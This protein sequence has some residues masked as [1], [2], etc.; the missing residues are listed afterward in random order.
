LPVLDRDRPL[1]IRGDDL[2]DYIKRTRASRK[3]RTAPDEFY[4]LG[5]RKA[6]GAAGS[7]ADCT[8]RDG[9]ATLTALCEV[10][11][12]VVYKPA[13]EVRI[14]EL[15]RTLDLKITRLLP[16]EAPADKEV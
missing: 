5:Y 9:R 10:C 2:R 14:P 6:R 15:A 11:E 12:A 7:V 3:V 4:C 13:P 16:P 1:L 8:I